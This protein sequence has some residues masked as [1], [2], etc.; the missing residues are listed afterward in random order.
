MPYT[1]GGRRVHLREIMR[2]L[3]GFSYL[4]LRGTDWVPTYERTALTDA[5]C[6]AFGVDVDTEIVPISK[7]K[8]IL[9]E[10]RKS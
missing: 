9:K 6:E 5:L 8:R 4:E 10:V 7:M 1:Q 3:K 2:A